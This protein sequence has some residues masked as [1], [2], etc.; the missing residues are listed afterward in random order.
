MLMANKKKELL[1]PKNDFVFQS[2]F[3]KGNEEITKS[4]IAALLEEKITSIKINETKELFRENPEDKLGILDLEAEINEKEKIDIEV[5]LIDRNN[6]VERL[7][8]YFSKLYIGEIKKGHNYTEAKRTVVIAIVDFKIDITKELR[9]METIW[10]L[11]EEKN[12]ELILTDKIEIHIIELEKARAEYLKDKNNKKAQW[13]LFIDNPNSEEVHKVM[14]ENKDIE[15]ATVEIVKMSEDEKMRKLAELREKAIMDEKS[16]YAAGMDKG[17][18]QRNRT[19]EK[20]KSKKKS[21]KNY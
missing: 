6:L 12:R 7:L 11:R 21:Q 9:Q 1:K 15:K 8:F 14:N 18:E 5:Q 4:M 16:I 2:L 17:I 13:M 20:W 10:K 3:S 19:T